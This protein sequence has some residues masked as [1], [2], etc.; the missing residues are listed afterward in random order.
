MRLT[1]EEARALCAAVEPYLGAQ[2]AVLYLYGS[3]VDDQRRGGD[4]DLVLVAEEP[5]SLREQSHHIVAEMKERL[6]AR[7]C[8]FAIIDA[9]SAASDVHWSDVLRDAVVLRRW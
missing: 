4:I 7:R 8:D 5:P 2:R 9:G 3:R 6:G 1:S